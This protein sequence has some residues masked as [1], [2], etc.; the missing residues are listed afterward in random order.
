ML[1]NLVAAFALLVASATAPA[2]PVTAVPP[3]MAAAIFAGGCFW[4]ME[5]PYDKVNGVFSTTSGYIGGN[6][7]FPTYDEVSSALTGHTEAVRGL[8]SEEGQLPAVAGSVWKNIDPV[9]RDRQFC[10]GG[11]QYR[12]GIFWL[13]EEQKKLAEESKA[14]LD[15]GQAFGSAAGRLQRVAW[16]P[17][18]PRRAIS[19]PPR[20]KP[21]GLLHPQSGALQLSP[22]R[23]WPRRAPEGTLGRGAEIARRPSPA[24][25]CG[26]ARRGSAARADGCGT[27]GGGLSV[28]ATRDHAEAARDGGRRRVIP[29]REVA[30]HGAGRAGRGTTA[31]PRPAST[32]PSSVGDVTDFQ[33]DG[34]LQVCARQRVVDQLPIAAGPRGGDQPFAC[35]DRPQVT[36]LAAGCMGTRHRQHERIAVD[37]LEVDLRHARS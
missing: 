35:P 9:V 10:D 5:P 30:K 23:L 7:K 4:C 13:D 29:T 28:A 27:L 19:G 17:R 6:K 1:K 14:L 8:R 31:T 36:P 20:S 37:R 26:R 33:R 3:G 25:V 12:S 18:S 16:S 2:Q 32:M 22:H 11:T 34:G 21:P 15:K 24:S